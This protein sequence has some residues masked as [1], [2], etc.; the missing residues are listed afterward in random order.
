MDRNR[1]AFVGKGGGGDVEVHL[2]WS[3]YV[4]LI[5]SWCNNDSSLIV[6]NSIPHMQVAGYNC[7]A[8]AT[9]TTHNILIRIQNPS[10]CRAH[11]LV[12]FSLSMLLIM[13]IRMKMVCFSIGL[14]NYCYCFGN[15]FVSC[16]SFMSFVIVNYQND[17]NSYDKGK[18]EDFR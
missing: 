9:I 1:T 7:N 10:F 6:P 14:C 13:L 11:L 4:K 2:L 18:R 12:F 17:K 16:L 8:S 3:C 5:G 15:F